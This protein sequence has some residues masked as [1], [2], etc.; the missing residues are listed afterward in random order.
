[1]G[2]NDARFVLRG[3]GGGRARGGM[4]SGCVVTADDDIDFATGIREG[5]GPLVI[6]DGDGGASSCVR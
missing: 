2:N 6:G 1:M 5:G 3:G 4:L